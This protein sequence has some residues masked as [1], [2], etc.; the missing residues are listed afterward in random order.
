MATRSEQKHADEQR[1]GARDTKPNKR[2]NR[3]KPGSAPADRLRSKKH[4]KRKATHAIEPDRKGRPS[5]ES[6]RKSANRSKPDTNL[7][8]RENMVKGSPEARFRK[9]D[10]ASD[11]VR[12]RSRGK[13]AGA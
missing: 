13:N 11:R 1:R 12:G 2:V 3:S 4:A 10:A 6:T 9:A 7:N 8:L 5:R